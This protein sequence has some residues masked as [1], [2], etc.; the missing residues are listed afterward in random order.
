M[1][2]VSLVLGIIG[3]VFSFIPSCS[4]VASI[5]SMAGLALGIIS[6]GNKTKNNENKT[7]ATWGI[8]LNSIG[9]IGWFWPL[10]F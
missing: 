4:L 1:D 3:I 9:V 2:I 5:I 8:V 6:L 7:K 10:I